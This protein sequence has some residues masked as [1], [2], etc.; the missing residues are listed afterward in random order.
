M[1]KCLFRSVLLLFVIVIMCGCAQEYNSWFSVGVAA[2]TEDPVIHL[3]SPQ[4]ADCVPGRFD[5][6]GFITDDREP[7]RIEIFYRDLSGDV[8]M[9][10]VKTTRDFTVTFDMYNANVESGDLVFQ[11]TAYDKADHKSRLDLSVTLDKSSPVITIFEPDD[12]GTGVV[13]KPLIGAVSFNGM[14]ND[15]YSL[16]LLSPNNVMK[17]YKA[18]DDTHA[19]ITMPLTATPFILTN[20]MNTMDESH[21]VGEYIAEFTFEDVNG[22][23]G[24]KRIKF[25]T[26]KGDTATRI[27]VDSPT[28]NYFAADSLTLSGSAVNDFL[29]IIR[30]QYI[31]S[32]RGSNQPI[33]GTSAVPLTLGKAN[34]FSDIIALKSMNVDAG[35]YNLRVTAIASDGSLAEAV[36]PFEFNKDLVDYDF[37]D[38]S[39]TSVLLGRTPLPSSYINGDFYIEIAAASTQISDADYCII[40][41]GVV[42]RDWTSMMSGSQIRTDDAGNTY[43]VCSTKVI[44]DDLDYTLPDGTFNIQTRVR[45]TATGQWRPLTR[46]LNI[47]R[48]PPSLEISSPVITTDIN[49][50]LVISGSASDNMGLQSVKVRED[51]WTD[52]SFRDADG[53]LSLWSYTVATDDSESDIPIEEKYGVTADQTKDVSFT[54]AAT[55]TAGNTAT[56]VLTV[57]ISYNADTPVLSFLMPESDDQ[58]YSGVM[59]MNATIADDDYPH[60]SMSADMNVYQYQPGK[61]NP[62]DYANEIPVESKTFT[63]EMI[64]EN[65]NLSHALNL[66]QD[67]YLDLTKYVIVLTG[68]GW[69]NRSAKPVMRRF[70]IDKGVPSVFVDSYKE[71]VTESIHFSGHVRYKS[72]SELDETNPCVMQYTDETG[73]SAVAGVKLFDKTTIN[74]DGISYI[75][76]TFDVTIDANGAHEGFIT[77]REPTVTW[78][79]NEWGNSVKLWTFRATGTTALQGWNTRRVYLDN[80]KPNVQITSPIDGFLFKD[81]GTQSFDL[82]FTV[83]DEPD[84]GISYKLNFRDNVK[85]EYKLSGD[86]D[87]T[88]VSDYGEGDSTALQGV[89]TYNISFNEIEDALGH[90]V[91]ITVQDWAGNVSDSAELTFHKTTTP[92]AITSFEIENARSDGLYRGNI[93]FKISAEDN[94]GVVDD[95][96]AKIELLMDDEVLDAL[97]LAAE[98]YPVTRSYAKSF[99]TTE[100]SDGI[101]VFSCRITDKS[102]ITVPGNDSIGITID[103][104]A[105]TL[106]SVQLLSMG[107]NASD[108]VAINK[109]T[110]YI[111]LRF[112]VDDNISLLNQN[113]TIRIGKSSGSDDIL[114]DTSLQMNMSSIRGYQSE[115]TNWIDMFELLGTGYEAQNKIYVSFSFSDAAGN[116]VVNEVKEFDKGTLPSAAFDKPAGYAYSGANDVTVTGT[117]TGAVGKAWLRVGAGEWNA[118]T[119]NDGSWTVTLDK[120]IFASSGE[121]TMTLRVMSADRSAQNIISRKYLVDIEAPTIVIT[122]IETYSADSG[123]VSGDNISGKVIIRGTY[124]DDLA[125]RIADI[126]DA[127]IKLTI[128]SVTKDVATVT[129][130]YN[131]TPWTWQLEWDTEKKSSAGGFLTNVVQSGVTVTASC[132]DYAGNTGYVSR[133][134]INVVPYITSVEGKTS[135]DKVYSVR[136]YKSNKWDNHTDE[137]RYSLASGTA[138]TVRG[139]NLKDGSTAPTVKRGSTSVTVSA[140]DIHSFTFTAASG[141]QSDTITV[142]VG[143]IATANSLY[144]NIWNFTSLTSSSR[145]YDTLYAVGYDMV[146]LNETVTVGGKTSNKVFATFARN[147]KIS[148]TYTAADYG[149]YTFYEGKTNAAYKIYSQVDPMFYAAAAYRSDS[150]L[151]SVYTYDEWGSANYTQISALTKDG[152]SGTYGVTGMTNYGDCVKKARVVYNSSANRLYLGCYDDES[153]QNT[154][155]PKVYFGQVAPTAAIAMKSVD[156]CSGYFDIAAA[157]STNYPVMI[158]GNGGKLYSAYVNKTNDSTLIGKNV[159]ITDGD[160]YCKM[161][162]ANSATTMHVVYQDSSNNLSYRR[163][164][165]ST[166]ETASDKVL[167]ECADTEIGGVK[168]GVTGY[169]TNIDISKSAKTKGNVTYAAGAPHISYINNSVL[170]TVTALRY[171]RSKSATSTSAADWEYMIVPSPVSVNDG[172]T[173]IRTDVSNNPV[174]LYKGDSRLY[175][176]RL[177]D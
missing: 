173:Y 31:I 36:V 166:Y 171:A 30:V 93:T 75:K 143:S 66:D 110:A 81:Q 130:N 140:S 1:N 148:P 56:R 154:P 48:T 68:H 29:D 17:I 27:T 76:E 72:G 119:L 40:R 13:S 41:N 45:K 22:N 90:K 139:Y 32:E 161:V 136:Y 167:L 51:N 131:G 95:G 59:T 121:Y 88:V 74:V 129:R 113:P 115:F 83:N 7:D 49:G 151:F 177:A 114:S 169:N 15:D 11:L 53:S 152:A 5:I 78:S 175:I 19:I 141:W 14:V 85:I 101:H 12:G 127:K 162:S 65:S 149:S 71:Y 102:G 133:D 164:S 134:G 89:N 18:E 63:E 138:V 50:A 96:L 20:V 132:V 24:S 91:R 111:G 124:T 107:E 9:Q 144:L 105:P 62:A 60:R 86:V 145:D 150:Q 155:V 52:T 28:P 108:I 112:T 46:V 58:K 73:R 47:D 163:V 156:N 67:K 92:P 82:K 117:Y 70:A 61:D 158:Y 79:D 16:N 10:T 23:L 33:A 25:S 21:D 84:A 116:I 106:A 103:N 137:L 109:W 98:S 77:G 37:I 55:D 97:D 172:A 118:V 6:R 120:G 44:V 157:Y 160:A 99:D 123:Y 69:K 38:V 142:K 3:T 80:H 26:A 42:Y 126:S 87:W 4:N 176:A 159:V 174:I 146:L 168:E 94:H 35:Q 54:V 8:V 135:S 34:S 165:G 170:N 2:D 57:T 128:G 104:T 122:G 39:D 43:T 147:T 153:R 100:W 125:D 64:R